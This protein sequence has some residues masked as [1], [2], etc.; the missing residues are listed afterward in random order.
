MHGTSVPLA[1]NPRWSC[2]GIDG[3]QRK[4]EYEPFTNHPTNWVEIMVWPSNPENLE[5]YEQ[6][7]GG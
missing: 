6:R 3:S 7:A 5:R 4:T 2:R 1:S